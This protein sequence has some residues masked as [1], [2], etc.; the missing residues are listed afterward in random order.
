MKPLYLYIENFQCHEKSE[1][2]FSSFA[3]ALIVGKVG[4]NEL[5]ANGVGKSSIFKA[6]E[7]SLFNQVRDPLL[8]KD[9]VLEKLIREDTDKVMVVF[10]FMVN[11]EIY[12]VVR[13]RTRKGISDLSFYKRNAVSPE[14]S[15]HTPET[16]KNLWDNI[17]SR[18]NSDTEADLA[19]KIKINYKAFVNTVH[20]MQFDMTSLANATPEKR[21]LILKESLELLVYAKLEKIAKTQAD[22]L[23]KEIEK[24]Q[25]LIQA[26]GDPETDAKNLFDKRTQLEKNLEEKKK[27][28]DEQSDRCTKH[29]D[30]INEVKNKKSI[31]EKQASTVFEKRDAL[32]QEIEKIDASILDF[33]SKKKATLS[34][35]QVL[36][37]ELNTLQNSKKELEVENFSRIDEVK[38][39][40]TKLSSEIG[41]TTSSIASTK[42]ELEELKIPMPQNGSCKHCRQ[43]LTNDHRY[44]C[45]LE[46]DAKI[47]IKEEELVKL[48]QKLKFTTET[49]K[50]S[51]DVLKDLEKKQSLF[52]S[53]IKDISSKEKELFEKK[54]SFNEYVAIIKEFSDNLQAKKDDLSKVKLEISNSSAEEIEKLNQYL[55]SEELKLKEEYEL[56]SKLDKDV[57]TKI[58]EILATN[59][60]IEEKQKDKKTKEDY[61]KEIE[62]AKKKYDNYPL[63]IQAF[64]TTG[65]PNLI[66]QNVLEDYQEEANRILSEIRP[67]LQLAFSTEKVKGDGN[68]DET[69]ELNYFLN[70]KPRDY[71]ILSGAQRLCI[72]FSLKLGL[73][74]LL[75]NTCGSQVMLLLLDE[76]DQA[77]DKASTDAFAKIIKHFQKDFTILVITHNDR[78]KDKFS[79]A[80]VVEQ[81]QN[82]IS[83][84]KVATSW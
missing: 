30:N 51:N 70:N 6:I 82:M 83:K 48:N 9:V 66:I 24:K 72:A 74:F 8:S 71:S 22:A 81:D 5:I 21:K 27:E 80:I 79:H 52:N 50:I 61:T 38:I 7:Y 56:L 76:V 53:V 41:F 1:I 62:E 43:V 17:T 55:T 77:L 68:L 63:V 44:E 39:N 64:G 60:F 46:I 20:F 31:L 16:D 33:S 58:G 10:D 69:L 73:A 32:L 23:L 37:N 29:T 42:S 15:G 35:A 36:T 45:Q 84:A 14:L 13:S 67:G 2:D 49:L 78:L 34:R 25:T 4:G 11:N 3:S 54:N 59:R 19:K 12:R 75:R 18:R 65:I 28:R 57:Q 26:L 47:K 40:L